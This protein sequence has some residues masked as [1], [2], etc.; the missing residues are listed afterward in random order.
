MVASFL[1]A[2]M[3]SLSSVFNSAST[4]FTYDIYERFFAKKGALVGRVECG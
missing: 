4:I 3:S 2:M 1:A